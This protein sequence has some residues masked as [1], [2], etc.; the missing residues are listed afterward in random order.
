MRGRSSHHIP[1]L[2]KRPQQYQAAIKTIK[3]LLKNHKNIQF[4]DKISLEL[5]QIV[6]ANSRYKN[7]FE[8]Y[9]AAAIKSRAF[10]HYR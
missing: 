10:S 6:F 9:K 3:A 4:I 5:S 8:D 7:H 1:V 2:L